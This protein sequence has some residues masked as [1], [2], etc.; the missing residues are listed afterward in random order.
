ME[1]LKR[2]CVLL[3]FLFSCLYLGKVILEPDFPDF[4]AHY[5]GAERVLYHQDPYASDPRYFTNQAYPPFDFLITMPFLPFPYTIAA[6]L[7]IA[8]SM[9][10]LLVVCMILLRYFKQKVMSNE[11]LLLV[12]L[13]LIAFPT[14]FSFGMGQINV[15][16]LLLLIL[17][18]IFVSNQRNAFA[19]LILAFIY[20]IKFFPL[21]LL[22]LIA[23]KKNLYILGYTLFFGI[24]FFIFMFALGLGMDNFFFFTS[25]LPD[26]LTSWKADY[27]NQSITGVIARGIQDT[28]VRN[29][30]KLSSAFFMVGLTFLILQRNKSNK[31]NFL[32]MSTIITL[33]LLVNTFSWQH[34]F[35]FLLP[36]FYTA[37]FLFKKHHLSLRY[38]LLLLVAYLLIAVNFAEPLRL[39]QL[40]Q[41]HV[42]IGT[43]LLWLLQLHLILKKYD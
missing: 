11:S 5:F 16:L 34:H 24:V 15:H 30:V 9:I 23:I 21:L 8:T 1:V 33:T 13:A 18:M 28:Q 10:S 43:L 26:L 32:S 31:V 20:H 40:I 36:V 38:Y 17:A 35:I 6:K 41:S 39:S 14:K 3:F 25:L 27:Y 42:F 12:S 4:R 19:G 2:I 22:P 7:W 29:I 37:Y